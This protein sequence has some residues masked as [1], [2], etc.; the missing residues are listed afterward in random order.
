MKVTLT[1]AEINEKG[2]WERYSQLKGVDY[3]A[4][5]ADQEV[6]FTEEEYDILRGLKKMPEKLEGEVTLCKVT[7]KHF[8]EPYQQPVCWSG[9]TIPTCPLCGATFYDKDY[10]GN[11]ELVTL[12]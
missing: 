1:E 2:W 8:K 4:K 12:E 6:T 10:S 11:H 9:D 3:Y 5:V 7:N